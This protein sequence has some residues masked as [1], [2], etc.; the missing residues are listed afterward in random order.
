[1]GLCFGSPWEFIHLP[2]E[3]WREAETSFL[4]EGAELAM[5][6]LCWPAWQG[7]HGCVVGFDQTSE[8]ALV[9]RALGL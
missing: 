9:R 5:G 2:Y 7:G 1:M 3:C 4:C 6:S 8:L